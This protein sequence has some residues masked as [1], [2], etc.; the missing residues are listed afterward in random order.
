MA[1]LVKYL[2]LTLLLF[3]TLSAQPYELVYS[4]RHAGAE[5]YGHFD[6]LL[7]D[8]N[9][10]AGFIYC[11]RSEAALVIDYFN[12]DTLAVISLGSVPVK[13]V[14]YYSSQRDTLHVYA[15]TNYESLTPGIAHVTISKD[16]VT[17][18]T[19][20]TGCFA[21][22]GRLTGVVHQDIFLA[23]DKDGA[24]SGLWFEAALRYEELT[25]AG[26]GTSEIVPTSLLYSLDLLSEEL[27]NNVTAVRRGNLSGDDSWEYAVYKNY[28]YQY[29]LNDFDFQPVSGQVQWTA[30]GV[31][32]EASM[33]LAKQTTDEGYTNAVFLGDFSTKSDNEEL[34]Y[35]GDAW[36]LTNDHGEKVSH[37]ACYAFGES[38]VSELWY[39]EISGVR[40]EHIYRDKSVIVGHADSSRVVFLDYQD[41]EII[42]TIE[43]DRN[44]SAIT[45]FETY[46]YPSTLN[47]VGR[48][49]DT[50]F[51]YRFDIST[52][53]T[54]SGSSSDESLPATFTLHQN[55][56]NPFNGE[57]R[58]SFES[59]EMQYLTL[60]VYNILGQEVAT[61][62]EGSF[63][64]GT[65]YAYWDGSDNQGLSQSSGVYFAK[66][67]GDIASQIIKLIYLK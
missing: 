37:I 16:N 44:L 67:Q 30:Y 1:K 57:T 64:P 53:L 8:D 9:Q 32:D 22:E 47:L 35:Y 42:D 19:I 66:L 56:P 52:R 49:D 24:I 18:R 2:F 43:F 6:P 31:Q 38:G 59:Q 7:D 5:N 39:Q 29:R 45:F 34:I 27:R 28:L 17:T 51:V 10:L 11:D 25:P 48:S 55:R 63:G 36:D 50:I 33:N 3:S 13:T 4:Q 23:Y 26:G 54:H 61:L 21:G 41:G 65:Y 14:H 60:K 58:L 15:L 40:F 12:A 20:S 62:T 46:A